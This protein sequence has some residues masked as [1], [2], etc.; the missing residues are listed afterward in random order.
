MSWRTASETQNAYFLVQ[1]STN[2]RTFQDLAQIPG[3]GNYQ[4]ENNYEYVHE[5]PSSGTNYYR[6]KQVDFDGHFEYSK[7]ISIKLSPEGKPFTL[8]PNPNPGQFT[9]NI[10]NPEEAPITARLTDSWGRVV[11]VFSTQAA[12]AVAHCDEKLAKGVYYL[13]ADN[14]TRYWQEKVVVQ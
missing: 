12:S 8:S 1:H 13:Q 3:K 11:W 2:G 7:I 4:Q 9:L 6:L 10:Q 14:G 5:N